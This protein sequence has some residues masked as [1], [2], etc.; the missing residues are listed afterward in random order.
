MEVTLRRVRQ[1][2]RANAEAKMKLYQNP[3]RAKGMDEL[4]DK[5]NKWEQLD[6]EL[7]AGGS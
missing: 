7:G 3:T 5:F 4:E 2:S 6:R 1:P